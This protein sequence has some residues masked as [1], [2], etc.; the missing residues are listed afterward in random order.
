MSE[1]HLQ[2]PKVGVIT[3]T[4]GRDSFLDIPRERRLRDLHQ[5]LVALLSENGCDVIDPMRSLR[6]PDS[7]WFGVRR[8]D[9]AAACAKQLKAEGAECMV[10]CSH[11]WTPPMVVI[12][13]VR[14]AN[15]PTM[16][17]TVDDPTLPGTVSISAVGASL[18]ES[19]VN[20]YAVQHERQRGNPERMLPWIRGSSAVAR[21]RKSAVMLWGGTYSLHMEH[22][23][24]DIPALKRLMIRDILNE[25][26]YALI[27]RAEKIL[28]NEPGRVQH[29]L[30]WLLAN[31]TTILYDDL[32]A[33]PRN[34]QVQMAYY[35]A[36]RDRLQ[37]LSGENIVG[38]SIR[39]QPTLSV[40]YGIVGCT[41]P[42]FLP[43]GFD[44]LGP[45]PIISTVCEGD[46]KGL[47]TSVLLQQIRPDVGP[48]FGDLKYV[49]EDFF[50]IS[51]CGAAS[52]WWAGKSNDPAK[53]LPNVTIQANVGGFTGAAV[54]FMGQAGPVT[55]ARLGRVKGQ[56][57]MHL[58]VGE[59]VEVSGAVREKVMGFFG[60]MWPNVMVSLGTD[61]DL[62]FRIAASNHPVATD[63]DVSAEVTYACRQLG[64]PIVRLDSNDSM[65]EHLDRLAGMN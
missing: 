53:S 44:D 27:R 5:E 18:L 19:G 33:S 37:E 42:A 13:T 58:G 40:E 17:Y 2:K 36:A 31:G 30:D 11:F 51:N 59:S 56:Y 38:V 25:G 10:L 16:V 12:D 32:S 52:V 1:N 48:I 54:G 26:E 41:L 20:Q 60:Q 24:D 50:A 8:Y 35:L 39:C 21:M 7:D 43:F 49:G 62:L 29:F 28:A 22:L 46:I 34:F 64:I 61:P 9:E 15:L 47:M 14:E 45:K 23:Q 55:T 63:G 65:R 4:D 57:V 3:F 6:A